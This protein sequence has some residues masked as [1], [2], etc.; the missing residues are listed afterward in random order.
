MNRLR[1]LVLEWRSKRL[2]SDELARLPASARIVL[3]TLI[4]W[5]GVV[6]VATAAGLIG[7]EIAARSVV[8]VAAKEAGSTKSA[9]GI[10]NAILQRPVFSRTRQAP[11]VAVARPLPPPLPPP[12]PVFAARDS[13]VR[14]K[15]VFMSAP[16]VKA[17][18]ISAQNPT[19]AWVKPQEVFGGWRVVEVRPS[20]VD[21]E[22]GG[23]RLTVPL[24]TGG[25][26]A[27]NEQKSV[28]QNF[29]PSP[30]FH[31]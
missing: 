11:V 16:M 9:R 19:G 8:P 24:G 17:F 20:E 29:R 10:S 21:L 13:D 26:G 12:P 7:V 18:V 25:A 23:E 27:A 22:S 3:L 15:G 6:L 5:S 14:L 31:R 1:E 28:V 4:G 30:Q 2:P